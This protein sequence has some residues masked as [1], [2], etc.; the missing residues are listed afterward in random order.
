VVSRPGQEQGSTRQLTDVQ[1]V[2]GKEQALAEDGREQVGVLA[3]A[4]RAEQHDVSVAPDALRDCPCSRFQYRDSGR[5]P[6]AA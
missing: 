6:F 4:D 5:S 2:S 1:H 3:R